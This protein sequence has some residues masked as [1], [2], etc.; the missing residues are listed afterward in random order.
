MNLLIRLSRPDDYTQDEG[1]RFVVTFDKARG[2]HGR[3]VAPFEAHLTPDGW[4]VHAVEGLAHQTVSGRLLEYLRVAQ[5]A[6]ERPTSANVAIARARVRRND[7]LKA[8][9][10][11]LKDRTIVKHPDGGF[12]V[13]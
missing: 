12:C 2:A 6:D 8:W 3:A 1:A 13:P 10:A 11:L 9:A 4:T 7:G 5:D